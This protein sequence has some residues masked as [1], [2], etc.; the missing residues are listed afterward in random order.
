[1]D[2][3]LRAASALRRALQQAT[4]GARMLGS[5]PPSNEAV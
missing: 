1:M 4:K 3:G 5:A 2:A